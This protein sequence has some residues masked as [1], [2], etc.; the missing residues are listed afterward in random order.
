MT[1][2][3]ISRH[4]L[5]LS[6]EFMAQSLLHSLQRCTLVNQWICSIA[7][8]RILE[9]DPLCISMVPVDDDGW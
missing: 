3:S 1:D 4:S 5:K 6:M 8:I 2:D 9:F 7:R